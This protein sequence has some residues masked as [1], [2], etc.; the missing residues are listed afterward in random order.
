M[1]ESFKCTVI[2][3]EDKDFKDYVFDIDDLSQKYSRKLNSQ[4]VQDS[5]E[6]L[7]SKSLKIEISKNQ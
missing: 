1:F 5:V 4:Q 7:F 6:K 2:T 3:K